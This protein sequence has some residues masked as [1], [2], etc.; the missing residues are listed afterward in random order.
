MWLRSGFL[1]LHWGLDGFILEAAANLPSKPHPS[2]QPGSLQVTAIFQ[3]AEIPVV[4]SEFAGP[5]S[6]LFQERFVIVLLSLILYS[7]AITVKGV[8]I[9]MNKRFSASVKNYILKHWLLKIMPP[10]CMHAHTY[11]CIKKNAS[12]QFR[13]AY[14]I[15]SCRNNDGCFNKFFCF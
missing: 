11:P 7:Q 6:T 5:I 2:L 12:N 9:S 14:F 4:F 15:I 3:F 1:A 8:N 13:I 10:I